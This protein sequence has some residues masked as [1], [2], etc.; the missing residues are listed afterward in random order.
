MNYNDI[1]T[2]N[3]INS[4]TTC[5]LC[6]HGCKVDRINHQTGFCGIDAN[7][8]IAAICVHKGEEP[9]IG[10]AQGVCNIFFSGCNLRCIYCQNHDISH[11]SIVGQFNN[12]S[13]QEA[14]DTI[15]EILSRGVT[16]VGFVSPSHAIPQMMA[17]IRGLRERGL[18]PIIVYNTNGYDNA[19]TIDKLEGLVDIFL[20]DF[21]YASGTTAKEYSIAANYPDIALKSI[22]RMY[23][24]KG[25]SLIINDSGI[26]SNGLIIR[27]LVLP[28]RVEESKLALRIIAE[29]LSP[30]VHISLMSQYYPIDEVKKHPSLGR[31]LLEEEYEEV[32]AEMEH[33][34]FRHGWIQDMDSFQTYRPDFQK[35]NPFE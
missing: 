34:G 17:I 5:S 10:G 30:G 8:S 2:A 23:Y 25:S 18:T 19:D 4:L 20:P 14:L 32:V 1:Y 7:L 21:K 35:A 3:E 9:A 6:P 12:F 16:T 29:E 27:H 15:E 22:K 13:I 26:A 11:S 31:P 33:L 28:N 24:Q